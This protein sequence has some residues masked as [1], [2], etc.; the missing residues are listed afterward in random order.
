MVYIIYTE[1]R[2]EMKRWTVTQSYLTID[3]WYD[4]K[5]KTEGEALDIICNALQPDKTQTEDTETEMIEE[6]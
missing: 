3:Y 1:R 4:V 6:V 5:A 2:N